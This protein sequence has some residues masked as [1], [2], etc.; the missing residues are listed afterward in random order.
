LLL[1]TFFS[2]IVTSLRA[3]QQASGLAKVQNLLGCQRAALG[4][5]SEA[6]RLLDP[7]LLPQIIGDLARQALPLAQG[8]EL[9]R[10]L[11]AWPTFVPPSG[12]PGLSKLMTRNVTARSSPQSLQ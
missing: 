12:A 10:A 8:R 7:A 9:P 3:L 11:F 5:L 1:L 6:S 4:L 2:P